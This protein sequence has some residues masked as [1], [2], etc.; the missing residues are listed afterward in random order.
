MLKL[1]VLVLVV[2]WVVVEV[3][4][5]LTFGGMLGFGGTLAWIA[6][7]A[8]LGLVLA[9]YAG[10]ATLL[11]IHHKLRLEEL[12]TGEL[13]DMGMIIVGAGLL[14]L[15][16]FVG[17]FLGMWLVLPPTRWISRR[18]LAL[19]FGALLPDMGMTRNG[20]RPAENVIEIRPDD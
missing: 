17:D 14:I 9:R 3:A 11:R 12:P 4:A 13:L 1:T 5:M 19:L 10:L 7:S 6:L 8:L 16:G 2:G 15:P 20:A 18:L